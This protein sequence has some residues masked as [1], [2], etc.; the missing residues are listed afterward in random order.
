[1]KIFES[2]LSLNRAPLS[3]SRARRLAGAPARGCIGNPQGNPAYHYGRWGAGNPLKCPKGQVNVGGKCTPVL[4]ANPVTRIDSRLVRVTTP[5]RVRGNK[6]RMRIAL[7]SQHGEPCEI[8]VVQ[9]GGFS[10]FYI[11]CGGHC[12]PLPIAIDPMPGT[13][14]RRRPLGLATSR[15]AAGN[16][17]VGVGH[18]NIVMLCCDVGTDIHCAPLPITFGPIPGSGNR[19]VPR[20]LAM[21][22]PR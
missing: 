20:R 22:Q 17:W 16:C 4:T 7:P 10:I 13:G 19:T 6:M 3:L 5:S 9:S 18:N 15:S 1:M 8:H 14:V 2:P 12:A 11:C 21:M